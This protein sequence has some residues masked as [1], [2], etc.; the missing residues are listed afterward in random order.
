MFN[1]SWHRFRD[2]GKH[3]NEEPMASEDIDGE[4]DP[5]PEFL[6]T[7]NGATFQIPEKIMKDDPDVD[8]WVHLREQIRKYGA[9]LDEV[10]RKPEAAW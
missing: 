10:T 5:T 4:A 6:T 1:Q 8:L 2:L 9:E 7:L 3:L